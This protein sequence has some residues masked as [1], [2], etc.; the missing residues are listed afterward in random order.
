MGQPGPRSSRKR[1]SSRRCGSRCVRV[2]GHGDLARG[3]RS[4]G[5]GPRARP[6]PRSVPAPGARDASAGAAPGGRRRRAAAGV[7][8]DGGGGA[9]PRPLVRVHPPLHDPGGGRRRGVRGHAVPHRDRR[10]GVP[11]PGPRVR[12]GRHDPRGVPV[13]DV[14]AGHPAAGRPLAGWPG[15]CSAGPARWASSARRSPSPATSRGGPRPCRSRSISRWRPTPRPPS[16]SP[17]CSSSCRSSCW[18]CCRD[19]WLR[20]GSTL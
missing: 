11:E 13:R 12:G 18:P 10:R 14:P 8:A 19:R 6:V 5:L 3:R 16:R 15:R 7:R 1:P 17:W 2:G 9:L 4:A 20:A